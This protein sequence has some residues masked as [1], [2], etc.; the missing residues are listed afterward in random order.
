[1]NVAKLRN[2]TAVDKALSITAVDKALSAMSTTIPK[3]H[4]KEG[5]GARADNPAQDFSPKTEL[6]VNGVSAYLQSISAMSCGEIDALIGDLTGLREKLAVD[7]R[8]IEQDVIDFAA[9]NQ[10]IVRLTEVVMD[11]VTHVKASGPGDG[12][13][14]G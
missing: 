8:R 11:S 6:T 1:M 9:L 3:A 10:S 7:E 4:L 5:D 12:M 2:S 13:Q 14:G